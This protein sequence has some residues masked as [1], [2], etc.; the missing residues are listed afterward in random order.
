MIISPREGKEIKADRNKPVDLPV[1]FLSAFKNNPA[2]KDN[3]NALSL[4]IRREFAEHI[5]SAKRDETRQLRLEK[6]IP[7]ILEGIGL[8]DRYRK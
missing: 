8:S 4:S 2:L 6:D 7:L 1:E 5:A 3:F